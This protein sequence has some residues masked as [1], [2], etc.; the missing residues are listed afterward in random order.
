[1]VLSIWYILYFLYY[2]KLSVCDINTGLGNNFFGRRCSYFWRFQ[3]RSGQKNEFMNAIN[4]NGQTCNAVHL[5]FIG[6][7]GAR[8]PDASDLTYFDHLKDVIIKHSSKLLKYQFVK[9]W[10]NYQFVNAS[11]VT[12]L[13]HLEMKYLGSFYGTVLYDLFHNK[14]SPETIRL[15]SSS[16]QRAHTSVRDFF[17]SLS[18]STNDDIN[19]NIHVSENNTLLRFWD[20][21]PNYK[22]SVTD[23]STV[24]YELNAFRNSSNYTSIIQAV[25]DRV[26]MNQTFTLSK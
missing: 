11:H 10:T 21:C 22:I 1:M 18:L 25:T 7:H 26:G 6:R 13:G 5:S 12:P 23:N 17:R 20:N 2:L 9:Y 19:K 24:M 8:L 15:V 3:Q 14:I 4:E 16:K